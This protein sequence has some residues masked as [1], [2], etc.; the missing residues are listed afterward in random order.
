MLKC[1]RRLLSG[2]RITFIYLQKYSG[3]LMQ[4]FG[5]L[6][7]EGEALMAE[8]LKRFKEHYHENNR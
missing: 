5:I 7:W 8:E 3:K 1:L 6:D 2:R 4:I